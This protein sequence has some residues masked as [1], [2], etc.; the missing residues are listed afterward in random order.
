MKNRCHLSVA[1]FVTVSI[2]WDADEPMEATRRRVQFVNIANEQQQH[3][4]TERR[5]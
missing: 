2:L 5:N 4:R 1:H 3:G